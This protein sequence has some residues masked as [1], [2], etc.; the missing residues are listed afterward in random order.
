MDTR[1]VSPEVQAQVKVLREHTEAKC[2][3][4]LNNKILVDKLG[5]LRDRW[6]DEHEYENFSDY[7][8]AIKPAIPAPF[9]FVKMAKRP[10]TLTVNPNEEEL[11]GILITL[12]IKSKMISVGY[13]QA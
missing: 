8:D 5:Y 13:I 7:I 3:V 6:Q 1:N 12:T 10:W 2:R 9:L 11:R 4:L